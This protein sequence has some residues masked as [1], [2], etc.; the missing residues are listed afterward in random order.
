M[1]S[2]FTT[3]L[4]LEL[5]GT[6]DNPGTWGGVLNTAAL[7]IID[8][9]LGGVQT[10]SLSSSNVVVNTAQSQN[11]CI[12]L[13]GTLSAN[14]DVTFP[15]I[16]R[17]YFIQNNTTGSFSV[18]IKCA[19]GGTSFVL[20]QGQA[21][22]IVLDGTN[23][24]NALA[25]AAI[26]AGAIS[27]VTITNSTLV[28]KQGTD[29][30]PT[31]SGDLQYS[32]QFKHLKAGDGSGTVR[33]LPGPAPGAL[34]GMSIANNGSDSTNDIDFA[35]GQ[36]ADSTNALYLILAGALTKRLDAAWAVG[37]NQ[38]GL[39][40]G[41]IANT[42]YH[43]FII[44]RPDTGVVDAGFDTSVTAAN[45]PANYTYYR[46]I[47]SIIRVSSAILG[48]VQ[49]GNRFDLKVPRATYDNNPGTSAVLKSVTVPIGIKFLSHLNAGL[50]DSTPGAVRY[51]L[52]SNPA[53]T[54]TA[55]SV[56]AF[57][58]PV[59]DGNSNGDMNGGAVDVVTDTSGRI[60]YRLSTSDSDIDVAIISMGWT[61]FRAD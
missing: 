38:G 14:V 58:V 1:A 39:F 16:G 47:G 40:S 43:C 13:T 8:Q 7:A 9:V 34:Y 6:G 46:R 31:T 35:V 18:T 56:S 23:V 59:W 21:S 19:G 52:L 30:T 28:L 61:D 27:A 55:A 11:N 17:N 60:R 2:T 48:F 44:M 4:N 32:T 37:N 26:T 3:N 25:N 50:L 24:V 5:Q 15:A 10:I 29:P 20:P 53:T 54:D 22:I 12:K 41:A 49:N 51:L 42:T 36:C 33:Y 57:T 45:R